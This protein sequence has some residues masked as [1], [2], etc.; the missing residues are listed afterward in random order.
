[1]DS[2]ENQ[3]RVSH[4]LN[5][6]LVVSETYELKMCSR[7]IKNVSEDQIELVER[8]EMFD[9][10]NATRI[11][12]VLIWEERN[13]DTQYLYSLFKFMNWLLLGGNA[14][15][16]KTIYDFFI[17]NSS[18]EKFFR[19]M[20][21]LILREIANVNISSRNSNVSKKN[22]KFG[23]KLM[24]LL[25][26]FCEGHNLDLQNYLRQQTNSKNNYDLVTLTTKLLSSY[27]INNENFE[28]VM[29]C[30]DTLT[31][32]IQVRLVI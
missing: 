6:N 25:Q 12:I 14:T 19:K 31:E 32:F 3:Q 1:L 29:Q 15:V 10:L 11:F 21:D 9:R 16:Q 13:G 22:L 17:T 28:S 23:M 8:Q 4:I 18:S 24:R 20:N 2:E 27:K 5:K 7:I 26:L 30:F